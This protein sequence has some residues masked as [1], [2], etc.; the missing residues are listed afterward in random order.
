MRDHMKSK[1]ELLNELRALRTRLAEIEAGESKLKFI[2]EELNDYWEKVA[3]AERVASLITLS[4]FVAQELSDPLTIIRLSIES[5][6]F[7]LGA[8]SS[9]EAVVENL[10]EGLNGISS[11]TS[12]IDKFRTFAKEFS[13]DALSKIDLGAIAN[14]IIHL[15]HKKARQARVTLSLIN[16]DRLPLIYSYEKDIEQLFFALI[17][18]AIEAA[19]NRNDR[20]LTITGDIIDEYIELRFSDTCGGISPKHLDRI[21]EPFFTTKPIGEGNGLGLCIVQHILLR[22]GGKV[23]LEN[24]F[25]KGSTFSVTLPINESTSSQRRSNGK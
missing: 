18:N 11:I 7:D 24:E 6:L 14:R 17:K 23:R 10:K 3:R 16:M 12:L 21:F 25:R 9:S 5:S 13:E 2:E 15:L 20:Q 19:D 8:G 1:T 4:V 22:S